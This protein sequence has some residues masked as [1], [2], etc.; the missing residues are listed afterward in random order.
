MRPIRWT[1]DKSM[2]DGVVMHVIDVSAEIVLVTQGMFPVSA[3]P[4]SAL[5][6]AAP[7]GIDAFASGYSP[8]KSRLNQHPSGRV[9][10]VV[11]RQGPHG[12]HVV[13][14]Y[15]HGVDMERVTFLDNANRFVQHIDV[16]HQQTPRPLGQVYGEKIGASADFATPV[17]HGWDFSL[18]FADSPQPTTCR[19]VRFKPARC[20]VGTSYV[21]TKIP[22]RG[23]IAD[24]PARGRCSGAIFTRVLKR[25]D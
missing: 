12:V 21:P 22:L 20:R 24:S 15:H 17:L 7:T 19:P 1:G 10:C 23:V 4:H 9:T 6:L 18:G 8:G 5:A 2:F 25:R 3:L 16:F 11:R 13:R 14:Q